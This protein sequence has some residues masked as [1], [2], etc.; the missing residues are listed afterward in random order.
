MCDYDD[1]GD[2]GSSKFWYETKSGYAAFPSD[3]YVLI[4]CRRKHDA[5]WCGL[6]TINADDPEER[7]KQPTAFIPSSTAD[8]DQAKRECEKLV[9]YVRQLGFVGAQQRISDEA[10][11]A[12]MRSYKAALTSPIITTDQEYDA[13][14]IGTAYVRDRRIYQKGKEK[15]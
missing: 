6:V 7:G 9:E 3:G 13:L 10:L 5:A 15:R 1:D 11:Q 12:S 8:V 4:V 14:P 2:F